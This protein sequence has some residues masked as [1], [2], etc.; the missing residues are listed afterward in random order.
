M[1]PIDFLR[2]LDDGALWLAAVVAGLTAA[3][4]LIRKSWRG[5]RKLN[6]FLRKADVIL[7]IAEY[8]LQHNGGGSIKDSVSKIPGIEK[9][10]A[11]LKAGA[12]V[13]RLG[14]V[15]IAESAAEMRKALD[16]H[17]DQANDIHEE[18][19]AAI[20]HLAEA[21][22]IIARSTPH[23]DDALDDSDDSVGP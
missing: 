14:A 23:H 1:Q 9:D 4:W 7:D 5:Y 17:V 10:V 6:E 18:Q 13:L 22:P 8:E 19:A 20:A 3:G 12:E 16:A 21:L 2:Q 15:G 11:D